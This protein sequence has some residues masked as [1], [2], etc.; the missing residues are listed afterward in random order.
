MNPPAL[1]VRDLVV[2]FG[3][4]GPQWRRRQGNLEPVSGVSLA[5][6]AGR[7]LGLVG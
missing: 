5:I 4:P 7:T 1:E 3:I 2:Q 6:P